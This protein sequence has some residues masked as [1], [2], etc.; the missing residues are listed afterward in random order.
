ML[1]IAI[2]QP[3]TVDGLTTEVTQN[4]A[5]KEYSFIAVGGTGRDKREAAE[6]FFGTIGMDP[7]DLDSNAVKVAY[8]EGLI[9]YPRRNLRRR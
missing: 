9:F 1:N 2:N 4:A 7:R 6:D 8:G 5:T 3:I